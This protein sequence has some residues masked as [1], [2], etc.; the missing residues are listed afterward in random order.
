[1]MQGEPR[2]DRGGRV[3]HGMH[4]DDFAERYPRAIEASCI[5]LASQN[6][7]GDD[8]VAARGSI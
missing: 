6:R 1:M 4:H 5:W 3:A 2:R 8:H 7:R